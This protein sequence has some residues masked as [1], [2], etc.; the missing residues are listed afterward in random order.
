MDEGLDKPL[1]PKVL[2]DPNHKAVKHLMYIYSM[3]SFIYADLN[4]V[5]REKDK[6]KIKFYGAFAAALSYIIHSANQN[7]VEDKLE[8]TTNLYRGV[9]LSAAEV[10]QYQEG[11]MINLLGYTSTSQDFSTAARFA[12]KHLKEEQIPVVFDITFKGSSGLFQLTQGFTAY[13]NEKEVLVQDGLTY[14]VIDNSEHV[15]PDTN[16]KFQIISLSYPA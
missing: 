16:Q 15:H 4:R 5:C 11:A 10:D 3:E 1:T 9:K 7:R 12:F 6:F 2:S 13:P 14:R 8:K